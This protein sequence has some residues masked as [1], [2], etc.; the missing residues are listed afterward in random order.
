[1]A[2]EEVVVAATAAAVVATVVAATAV[3]AAAVSIGWDC[4][5]VLIHEP[6]SLLS[7]AVM[8]WGWLSPMQLVH[9][10]ML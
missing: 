9:R 10:L 2:V 4:S 6:P 5:V 1:M 8:P 3:V 7:L